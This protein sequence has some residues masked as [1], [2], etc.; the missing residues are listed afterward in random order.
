[1]I[2]H[3]P[4]EETLSLYAFGGLKAGARLVVSAHLS[5]CRQCRD[6]VADLE[7]VA[8]VVLE[9]AETAPLAPDAL[10]RALDRLDAPAAPPPAAI[11]VQALVRQGWWLPAA[12]GL[13]FKPLSRRADPGEKLYLLKARAGVP[14]PEHGHNGYER[15]VVLE[16]AFGDQD[17]LYG[18]GD[19]AECDEATVHE[20]FAE[21]AC[22]CLAA[23]EGPLR[24]SG[25][26][27]WVQPFLGV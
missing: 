13:W 17:G 9:T 23:T 4:N 1:M 11:G 25:L 21:T 19:F 12:P 5:A 3:H 26:A 18:P 15:L 10:T 8:G 14:L 16:G 2:R 27:R 24:L 7:A 22:I 20:P 6:A